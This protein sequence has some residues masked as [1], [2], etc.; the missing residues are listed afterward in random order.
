LTELRD[1]Y[2]VLSLPRNASAEQIRSRFRSLVRERHPDRLQAGDR[3]QAEIEFQQITEAFNVLSNPERRRLHD[4]ELARPTQSEGSDSTRLARFH[5]EA[6]VGF[7]RDGN[8]YGAMEAF[9][10][11]LRMDPKQHQAW[12]HLAEALS[13]QRTYLPRA[14]EASARACELSPM[15]SDY[16][17]LAGRLHADA[18]LLDKAERYYNEA[19]TW[20]GEDRVVEKALDELRARGKKPR[21]GIFGKGS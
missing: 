11:V 13:H 17:K 15:N 3:H 12:F 2:N 18:G 9:D 21:P 14:V 4:F 16:L 5:L 8:F 19:Q 7:L 10:R 1:F 6:G 20:G